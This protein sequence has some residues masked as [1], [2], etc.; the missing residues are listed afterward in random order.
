MHIVCPPST[1]DAVFSAL[2][3]DLA[4][5]LFPSEGHSPSCVCSRAWICGSGA[6]WMCDRLPRRGV[7]PK[8]SRSNRV[9]YYTVQL[10]LPPLLLPPSFLLTLP[11]FRFLAASALASAFREDKWEVEFNYA[12]SPCPPAEPSTFAIK[13]E[14]ICPFDSKLTP[15]WMGAAHTHS[16]SLAVRGC[17]HCGGLSCV[18]SCNVC[19][20]TCHPTHVDGMKHTWKTGWN[21]WGFQHWF[22]FYNFPF[23]I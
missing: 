14:S 16:S 4:I 23:H 2:T 15:R 20:Y 1:L 11:V 13:L 6:L 18:T 19:E 12:H 22:I 5:L 8:G 10:F 3:G 7:I 21:E 17:N 9:I